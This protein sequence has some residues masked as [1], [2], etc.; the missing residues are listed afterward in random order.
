MR[1]RLILLFSVLTM[2]FSSLFAQDI[3][4]EVITAFKKGEPEILNA[5]LGNKLEVII[6][7]KALVT[8]KENARKILTAFFRENKTLQFSVNHRG[9]RDES[10]FI[11]GTLQTVN[12]AYRVNCF[13]KKLQN[14]YVIHQIRIDK[15]NE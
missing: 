14:N 4:A 3:P 2:W 1:K 9:Q 7:D 12:G 15:T 6:N 13:L 11:I 8:D 10:S 5:Y